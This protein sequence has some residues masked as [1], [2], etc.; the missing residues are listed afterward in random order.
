MAVFEVNSIRTAYSLLRAFTLSSPYSRC[1]AFRDAEAL[2]QGCNLRYLRKWSLWM[3]A[4]RESSQSALEQRHSSG[5]PPRQRL[6]SSSGRSSALQSE[7]K[8]KSS[9]YK[10]LLSVF[11]TM[12]SCLRSMCQ[13]HRSECEEKMR[14]KLT[15][16]DNREPGRKRTVS[17][18]VLMTQQ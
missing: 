11:R 8:K 2:N 9:H 5:Y 12:H 15:N 13:S 16:L 4:R 18:Y 7:R 14:N 3:V 1:E 17:R 10:L 6:P